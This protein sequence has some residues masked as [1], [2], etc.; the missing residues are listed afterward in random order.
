MSSVCEVGSK[1]LAYQTYT[2][3]LPFSRIH[4][5]K[6]GTSASGVPSFELRGNQFTA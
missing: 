6:V 3:D 1:L 4:L 5:S 2:L